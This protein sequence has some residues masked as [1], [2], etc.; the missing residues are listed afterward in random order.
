MIRLK[1]IEAGQG[2]GYRHGVGVLIDLLSLSR[3]LAR[4]FCLL[5]IFFC[6]NIFSRIRDRRNRFDI[7]R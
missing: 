2:L 4:A 3:F 5:I 1:G 7:L 6:S